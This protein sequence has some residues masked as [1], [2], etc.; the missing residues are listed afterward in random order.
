VCLKRQL[1][2]QHLQAILCVSARC[3]LRIYKDICVERWRRAYP[4]WITKLDNAYMCVRESRLARLLKQMRTHIPAGTATQDPP[5][6][7]P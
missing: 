1:W 4:G 3:R 5:A 6:G 7:G 2:C